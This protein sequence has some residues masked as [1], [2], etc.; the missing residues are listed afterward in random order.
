VPATPVPGQPNADDWHTG[1]R[2]ITSMHV[3]P[4]D[5][6]LYYTMLYRVEPLPGPGELRRIRY[7]APATSVAGPG[8]EAGL[9]FLGARPSPARGTAASELTW[10]QAAP[11]PVALSIRDVRGRL[12][13]RLATPLDGVR[14]AG[15]HR[16][17]WDGRDTGGA[18]VA[19]GVYV[20]SI[21]AQGTRRALRLVRL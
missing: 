19:A 11:G 16:V 13:R 1:V 10:R 15:E 3:G 6:A 7:I 18:A 5:G 2:Y 20:A 17:S 8:K 12:V 9:A 21:E 14:A 4:L